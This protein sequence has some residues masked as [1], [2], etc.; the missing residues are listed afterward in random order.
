[1]T[2][3]AGGEAERRKKSERKRRAAFANGVTV[4]SFPIYAL[5]GARQAG[6]VGL[7]EEDVLLTVV[8]AWIPTA[9][10]Q[11]GKYNGAEQQIKRERGRKFY[12]QVLH[13]PSA[14]PRSW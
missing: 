6:G 14:S 4:G 10:A 13:I 5:P 11:P 7:G 8:V 2:A 1:M 12:T 9:T 3:S